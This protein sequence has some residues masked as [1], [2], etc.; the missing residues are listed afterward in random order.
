MSSKRWSAP[1]GLPAPPGKE[2]TLGDWG[3]RKG[4]RQWLSGES[5]TPR[6]WY[7][8]GGIECTQA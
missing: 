2:S 3:G 4:E 1:A 8:V 6:A 5:P 7:L